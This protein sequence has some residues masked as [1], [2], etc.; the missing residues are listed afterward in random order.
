MS[1]G[2]PGDGAFFKM[3]HCQYEYLGF[4]YYKNGDDGKSL[5]LRFDKLRYEDDMIIMELYVDFFCEQIK[6][7]FEFDIL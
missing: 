6:I 3:V 2:R 7:E 5:I 4:M 1:N